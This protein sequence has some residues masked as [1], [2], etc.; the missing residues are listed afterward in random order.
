METARVTSTSRA[1]AVLPRGARWPAFGSTTSRPLR[2]RLRATP[3]TVTT[4]DG[5][6]HKLQ[7]EEG[8]TVLEA[9]IE[10]GEGD[11]GPS[12]GWAAPRGLRQAEGSPVRAAEGRPAPARPSTHLR[13][14]SKRP[15][16]CPDPPHFRR[17]PRAQGSRSATTAPWACA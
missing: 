6:K 2:L 13:P 14:F 17:H 15:L 7:V 12:G 11:D 5:T 8:Q 4:L 10:Q 3:V 1:T 9:C 16:V